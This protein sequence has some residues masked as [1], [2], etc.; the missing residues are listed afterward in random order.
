MRYDLSPHAG[1]GCTEGAVERV[2]RMSLAISV[3]TE[4]WRVPDVATL[5]RATLIGKSS[6][7]AHDRS[8]RNARS[9]RADEG[10]RGKL[11]AGHRGAHGVG[12]GGEGG[13]QGHHPP[14][15]Q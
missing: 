11:R 2:A 8:H 1:R 3:N 6:G 9:G 5:I 14:R 15:R 7:E 12:D 4:P 10:R 13:R